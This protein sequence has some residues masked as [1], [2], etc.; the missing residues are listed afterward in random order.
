M[1]YGTGFIPGGR[2]DFRS[3]YDSAEMQD[4]IFSH[5]FGTFLEL[6]INRFKWEGLPDEIDPRYLEYSLCNTGGVIFFEDPIMGYQALQCAWTGFD[7]Y[8]NPTD[9]QVV[10][11]TGYS[12]H[13]DYEEGVMVWNN[14]LRVPDIGSI[15]MFAHNITDIYNSALVNC[16]SQKHPVAI[17]AENESEKLSL[18]NAY[19]DIDGNKPVIFVKGKSLINNINTIDTKAPFVAQELF[20]I[21]DKIMEEFLK[22]LGVKMPLVNGRERLVAQE[23]ADANAV[24]WQLR[25]RGLHS[26]QVAAE[27]INKK[28]GLDLYVSF[29]E[30]AESLVAESGVMD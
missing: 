20:E 10:T 7:N 17:E 19:K 25:N 29:N 27:Q 3:I 5:Y 6:A 1:G 22:W 28:F 8:L 16:R 23:Q 18:I 24:T 15:Y 2:R 14:F 9:F 30:D 11:P 26:R 13:V 4:Q 21:K 12:P